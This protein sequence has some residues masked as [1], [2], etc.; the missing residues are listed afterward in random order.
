MVNTLYAFFTTAGRFT[1]LIEVYTKDTER[2]FAEKLKNWL[3]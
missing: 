1:N 2:I 3:V